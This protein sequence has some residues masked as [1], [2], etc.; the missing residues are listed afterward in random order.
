MKNNCEHILDK[1]REYCQKCGMRVV[2]KTFRPA[3]KEEGYVK[4]TIRH[5]EKE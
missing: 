5:E 3:T 4:A 2:K 1:N